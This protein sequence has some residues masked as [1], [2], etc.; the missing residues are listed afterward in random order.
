[1]RKMAQGKPKVLTDLCNAKGHGA[2]KQ[3]ERNFR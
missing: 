1:M 2:E 3:G